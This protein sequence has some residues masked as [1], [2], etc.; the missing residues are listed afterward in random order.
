MTLEVY[1]PTCCHPEGH[2]FNVA[3]SISDG[4]QYNLS[5]YRQPFLR[6]PVRTKTHNPLTEVP[7]PS[8]HPAKTLISLHH[9][10][11]LPLNSDSNNPGTSNRVFFVPEAQ[12]GISVPP[13]TPVLGPPR[14]RRSTFLP[15][16]ERRSAATR[17]PAPAPTM[18]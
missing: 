15:V 11:V 3:N 5:G 17:P 13:V 2:P 6:K 14:S 1:A 10:H 12:V 4:Y 16:A 9:H 8:K 7:P 18:M